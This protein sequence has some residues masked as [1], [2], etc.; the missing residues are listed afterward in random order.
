MNESHKK[1]AETR[2]RRAE[3]QTALWREQREVLRAAR[4]ALQKLLENPDATPEQILKA[5]ELLV[6]LGKN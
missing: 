5:G 1:A 3:E 4:G 6:Q 2:Q